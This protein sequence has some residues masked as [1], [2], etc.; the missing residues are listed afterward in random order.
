MRGVRG[1]GSRP[2]RRRGPH[3]RAAYLPEAEF[4]AAWEQDLLD[5][6]VYRVH[7]DYRRELEDTLRSYGESP[8]VVVSVVPI[9]VAGL[10][11]YAAREGKNPA[12]RRTRLGYTDALYGAGRDIAWPPRR[13]APCWCGSGRGYKKCCG[14]P[15]FLAVEMPDPAS[16]VLKIELD[17]VRP[18]VWRRIAVPSELRLDRLHEVIQTAMDWESGRTYLFETNSGVVADPQSGYAGYRAD[19][20]VLI[21][22]ANEI[23]DQFGYVYD[24]R[25]PATCWRHTVTVEEIREADRDN[26]PELLDGAGACP[27]PAHRWIAVGRPLR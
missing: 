22:N 9:D 13:N 16:L 12:S 14:A 18:A 6:T 5:A 24:V 25:D 27:V 4:D 10:M 19:V 2:G 17:G 21:A 20:E 11:A 15:G 1:G 8:G 7:A 23:G 26:A 3:Y